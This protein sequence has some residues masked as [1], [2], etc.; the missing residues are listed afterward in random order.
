MLQLLPFPEMLSSLYKLPKNLKSKEL[1]VK[2]LIWEVSD[3]LTE[4][5]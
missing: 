2:L 1:I 3:H 4:I 5:Q